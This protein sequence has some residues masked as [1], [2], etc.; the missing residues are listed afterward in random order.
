MKPKKFNNKGKENT[1]AITQE[2][3]LGSESSD[4]TKIKAMEFQGKESITSISSS[5]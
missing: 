2:E 1:T 5:N 3:D 4:E